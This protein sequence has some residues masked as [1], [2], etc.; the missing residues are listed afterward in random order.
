[1]RSA[2]VDWLGE[3]N[4]AGL[5]NPTHCC[6]HAFTIIIIQNEVGKFSNNICSLICLRFNVQNG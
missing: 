3:R 1:M 4:G 6:L 2:S 5:A